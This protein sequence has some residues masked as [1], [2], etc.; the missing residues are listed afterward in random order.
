M[1]FHANESALLSARAL[2]LIDIERMRAYVRESNPLSHDITDYNALVHVSVMLRSHLEQE[3]ALV[4][5]LCAPW[6]EHQPTTDP[7]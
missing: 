3:R 5:H 4:A 7:L 1:R 6:F 2:Q